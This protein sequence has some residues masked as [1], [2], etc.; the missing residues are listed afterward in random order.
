MGDEKKKKQTEIRT[1]PIH[2][3][4]ARKKEADRERVT[5]YAAVY[6]EFAQIYD[7]FGDFFYERIST[8]AMKRTLEAGHD[9]FA[10]RNHSWDHVVGRTGQNLTLRSDENGLFFDLTPPKTTLGRDVLEEVKSGLVNQCSIGFRVLEDD[11]DFKGDEVFRTITD[12]ELYEIS[13]NEKHLSMRIETGIAK[14]KS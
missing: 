1:L 11:W 14:L 3:L 7:I 12:L 5:G 9:I 10:L 13:N 4:E 8:G 2:G 6:D